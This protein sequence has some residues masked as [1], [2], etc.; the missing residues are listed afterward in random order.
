M[1]IEQLFEQKREE[2]EHCSGIQ[3][4]NTAADKWLDEAGHWPDRSPGLKIQEA[5]ENASSKMTKSQKKSA[6]KAMS[7]HVFLLITWLVISAS[8]RLGIVTPKLKG[9]KAGSSNHHHNG[10]RLHYP[11][12]MDEKH[13]T[14]NV[15][16][17]RGLR[18]LKVFRTPSGNDLELPKINDTANK[19]FQ[20]NLLIPQEFKRSTC[21]RSTDIQSVQMGL[22]SVPYE[23]P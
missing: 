7:I 16:V 5:E 14:G 8:A 15:G 1:T 21:F 9:K 13:R 17:W 4:R 2:Q 19:A 6:K 23:L 18:K 10:R 22:D 20:V 12:G 11:N 3:R